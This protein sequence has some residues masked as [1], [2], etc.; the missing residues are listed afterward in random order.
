M[1]KDTRLLDLLQKAVAFLA[2]PIVTLLIA[3]KLMQDDHWTQEQHNVLQPWIYPWEE[4]TQFCLCIFFFAVCATPTTLCLNTKSER[5]CASPLP[6][7][8]GCALGA[9]FIRSLRLRRIVRVLTLSILNDLWIGINIRG[10]CYAASDLGCVS[11]GA[12]TRACQVARSVQF[13]SI[14]AGCLMILE[15]HFSCKVS[16]PAKE[17]VMV[18]KAEAGTGNIHPESWQP[19]VLI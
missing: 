19:V 3:S 13:L 6:V 4:V 7:L 18:E 16:K 9:H 10:L 17:P 5:S 8:P 2:L 1:D 11:T 15:I 12:Q 14:F